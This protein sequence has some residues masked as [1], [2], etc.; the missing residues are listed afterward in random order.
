MYVKT[1]HLI[2]AL[3]RLDQ[4]SPSLPHYAQHT[5]PPNR[6]DQKVIRAKLTEISVKNSQ[7]KYFLKGKSRTWILNTIKSETQFCITIT[8]RIRK[9]LKCVYS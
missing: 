4:Q 3:N 5:G 9:S 8:K 6:G 7:P 1:L 2:F